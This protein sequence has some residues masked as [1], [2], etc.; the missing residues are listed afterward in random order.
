MLVPNRGDGHTNRGWPSGA[1]RRLHP[2]AVPR[3]PEGIPV[4]TPVS[5][6]LGVAVG[7]GPSGWGV[8]AVVHDR[9]VEVYGY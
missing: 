2:Q 9:R 7:N 6:G 1:E 4:D 8:S 5:G 3:C